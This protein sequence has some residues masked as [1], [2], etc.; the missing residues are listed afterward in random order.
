MAH[1]TKRKQGKKQTTRAAADQRENAR[2]SP[3]EKALRLV[4]QSTKEDGV[5][6]T[7]RSS[8]HLRVCRSPTNCSQQT[9]VLQHVLGYLWSCILKPMRRNHDRSGPRQT[10]IAVVCAVNQGTGA[11]I[12]FSRASAQRLCSAADAACASFALCL[13]RR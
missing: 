11:R 4:H 7:E 8:V 2:A 12:T 6:D 13:S 9:A 10:C 5:H 3:C 1:I